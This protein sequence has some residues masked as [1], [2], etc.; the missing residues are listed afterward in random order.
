MPRKQWVT[1]APVRHI[2][3]TDEMYKRS[4]NLHVEHL[5]SRNQ[6]DLEAVQEMN[7]TLTVN[8]RLN[9]RKGHFLKAGENVPM[10]TRFSDLSFTN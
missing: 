1:A 4:T 2:E 9:L 10:G 6:F 8:E 7:A 5:D 3:A